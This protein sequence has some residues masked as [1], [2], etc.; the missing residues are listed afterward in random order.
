MTARWRAVRSAWRTSGF[1]VGHHVLDPG[2]ALEAVHRQVLA[3]AG[4]LEPAVRHLGHDGDMGVDPDR[5]EV[6]PLGHPHRPAV[7][8][9]PYARG[10]AVLDAVGPLDRLVLVGEALHRDHRPEDLLLDHLVL[11]L[12]PIDHGGLVEVAPVADLVAAGHDLGVLGRALDKALDPRHLVGVVERTV[13]GVGVTGGAGPGVPGLLREGCNEVV[14]DP[15]R[16]QHPG[17]GG[18]VL[19]GVEVPGAGDALGRRID[20]GVVEYDHGRLAA[21]LQ[22]NL[23]EVGGRRL[24]DFDAGGNAAGDGD[25]PGC[26]V[27]DHGAPRVAGA[28]D[29]VEYAGRQVRCHELGHEEG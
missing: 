9:G 1:D 6:Q 23:L 15:R 12:Q 3:V 18:A 10:E 24:G 16:R 17:G 21:E 19:A 13:G 2:V 25:H 8:L 7:V 26:F 11:L 29:D 22:V 20:I 4:V 5:P 14:V 27:G 28:A